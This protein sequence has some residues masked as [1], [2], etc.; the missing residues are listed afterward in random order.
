MAL[1]LLIAITLAVCTT[2][3]L[4]SDSQLEEKA[5]LHKVS[6]NIEQYSNH[7]LISNSLYE[8]IRPRANITNKELSPDQ[9]DKRVRKYV[10]EKYAPALINNYSKIYS[11]MRKANKDF[12]S[13]EKLVPIKPDE[14]VLKSLCLK[15]QNNILKVQYMT[16]GYSQGWSKSAVFVFR[17]VKGTAK[18]VSIELQPVDEGVKAYVEGI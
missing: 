3:S 16:N 1:R 18:L 4:A 17:Y 9:I 6:K 15:E 5:A 7:E 13:C 8:Q 11:E 14:D 2:S 10:S 12:T